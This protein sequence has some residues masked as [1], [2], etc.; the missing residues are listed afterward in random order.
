[1]GELAQRSPD[2]LA[3]NATFGVID[4]SDGLVL[5]DP[6][7]SAKGAAQID[8]AGPRHSQL[9]P[10]IRQMAALGHTMTGKNHVAGLGHVEPNAQAGEGE[11]LAVHRIG[12]EGRLGAQHHQ[13]IQQRVI[14]Q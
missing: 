5:V 6:G 11:L 9:E 7:G 12:Q 4:T 14:N 1:M 3:N 8:A 2:N 13:G 10:V